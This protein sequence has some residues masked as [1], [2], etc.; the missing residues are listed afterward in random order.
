MNEVRDLLELGCA[1]WS[2]GCKGCTRP[3]VRLNGQCTRLVEAELAHICVFAV[4]F[5]RALW[6]SEGVVGPGNVE[7]VVHDLEEHAKFRSE[8]LEVR[9]SRRYRVSTEEELARESHTGAR[10]ALSEAE[11]DTLTLGRIADYILTR[12]A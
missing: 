8:L 5:V 12:T 11:G 6:L 7:N 2:R 3:L 10:E 4:A 1:R 9:Q